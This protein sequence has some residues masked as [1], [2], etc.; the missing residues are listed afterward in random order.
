MGI[1]LRY[2]HD[3][4]RTRGNARFNDLS[5]LKNALSLSN[6]DYAGLDNFNKLENQI[7]MQ[8]V[9]VKLT[10][11]RRKKRTLKKKRS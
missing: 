6:Q 5:E 11:C 2:I 4:F 9:A 1:I 8:G 3:Y 7:C 10:W